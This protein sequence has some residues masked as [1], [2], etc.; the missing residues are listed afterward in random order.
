[1]KF[2][3]VMI[4]IMTLMTVPSAA[5]ENE[6][7]KPSGKF[8]GLLFANYHTSF[9]GGD[10]TSAFEVARSYFG[11][12]FSFSK[13]I[14]SR[15]MYDGTTQVIN[16]KTIYSGYLRN[17]YLQYDNGRFLVRGGL[18]GMEQISMMERIWSYR[19]ITKPPV[20][21]SGMVLPA[22]LG[23]MAKFPAGEMVTFDLAVTNGRGFKDVTPNGTYRLS[24][25]FT[26]IPAENML[27][28]GFYDIMGPSG[29]MQRTA[30]IVA[31]WSSPRFNAG[32]EY[33]RQ[34]NASMIEERDYSGISVFASVP[35]AEKV[36]LFARWD[37]IM[38]V[39]MEGAEDP[40]NINRDGS[41]IFA[42]I[43]F[44]PVRNVRLSPNFSGYIPSGKGSDI[45]STISLNISAKF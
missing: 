40:W 6:E 30:S 42:G 13:E 19:F 28:R 7:F 2:L 44:S 33:F 18:I 11:Y 3:P 21:Y 9:S 20:D 34:D 26:L 24:A 43:D 12:D 36:K 22:D 4:A 8:F 5:Q 32:A 35:V 15:V 25:G 45:V 1:M 10:N 16:G 14:S 31:A 37:R 39:T 27:I 29:R 17:A 23:L 41:Y 38:S